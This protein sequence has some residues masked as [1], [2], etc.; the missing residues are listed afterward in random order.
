MKIK[1]L[2]TIV[3][4]SVL[5]IQAGTAQ[6]RQT[7]EFRKSYASQEEIISLN[8]TMTFPQALLIFNDLSKKF[9]GK[10]I[11]DPQQSNFAIGETIDRMHWMDALELIL[12]RHDLWYED[13]RDYIKIVPMSNE[14]TP[15]TPK[16]VRLAKMAFQ[17]REVVFSAIFFETNRSK[18]RQAGMSWD[19]Y[20]GKDLNL[21]TSLSAADTK[22][23]LYEI[24]ISPD[25]DF[26][27]LV[28]VFKALENDQVG[29]VVANPQ[30]T[31][32]SGEEGRV[33]VGSDIAV[34]V[35][36]FA[37]NAITQFYS[38]GSIIRVK[39]EVI[40]Y[41]SIN[42]I[43]VDLQI[44]RSNTGT[45]E[46]G[47]EIK[48]STAKTSIMLLD[49]EETIIGGLYV[50][51]D[52]NTREG[53]PFLKDLPWWFFGLRY[54]F[55]HESKTSIKNELLILMKA[56]L[57]PTLEERFRTKMQSVERFDLLRSE[58]RKVKRRLEFLKK[59]WDEDK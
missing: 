13:Y 57:L 22:S 54:V 32:M 2:L 31:V 20:R 34:T 23:G 46:A 37:G 16:E 27:N 3:I 29:E 1:A 39:P 25:L 48:K 18:L 51:E 59:Q 40:Q 8:P 52:R 24:D 49:G 5:G 14:G 30:V 15:D 38:T 6:N 10:L 19:F 47:L 28:A 43:N 7:R 56:D 41:D 26:G 4:I 21:S 35:Q 11:I 58:K 42:F 55:G 50:T 9:L 44:E 12:Q 36:D 17:T 45:S 53:I 33:Q